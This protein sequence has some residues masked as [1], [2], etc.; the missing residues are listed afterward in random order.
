MRI[1]PSL[2]EI[3]DLRWSEVFRSKHSAT[4][5]HSTLLGAAGEHYELCQLLRRGYVA[6]PA[7]VGLPNADILI[8]D[9]DGQRLI[10]S[11]VDSERRQFQFQSTLGVIIGEFDSSNWIC[12]EPVGHV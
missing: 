10:A 6:P 3:I 11:N 5:L 9:T 8:T 4:P 7:P 2:S 1:P 12:V